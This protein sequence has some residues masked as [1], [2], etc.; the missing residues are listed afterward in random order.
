MSVGWM[1]IT[2]LLLLAS[3]FLCCETIMS[4]VSLK[5]FFYK[6]SFFLQLHT[7]MKELLLEVV[8]MF[9]VDFVS[10]FHYLVH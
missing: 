5:V 1:M 9:Y 2:S 7:V 3:F 4:L 6:F 8:V 10:H